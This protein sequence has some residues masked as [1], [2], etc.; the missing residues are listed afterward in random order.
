M[1]RN[2]MPIARSEFFFRCIHESRLV[3][4][5]NGFFSCPVAL[6]ARHPAVF[7]LKNR[8]SGLLCLRMTGISFPGRDTRSNGHECGNRLEKHHLPRRGI[9]RTGLQGRSGL[10][11]TAAFR[12]GEICPPLSGD[13]EHQRRLRRGR[14]WRGRLRTARRLHRTH[15]GRGAVL[16]PDGGGELHQ[17]LRRSAD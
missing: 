13:G 8:I 5:L 15:P 9:R 17:P 4:R 14:R 3:F 6:A 7:P 2:G 10:A 12:Q 11:E 16:R 1:I